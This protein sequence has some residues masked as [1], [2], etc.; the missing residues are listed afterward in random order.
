MWNHSRN[1]RWKRDIHGIMKQVYDVQRDIYGNEDLDFYTA[2]NTAIYERSA[3]ANINNDLLSAWD[4][5]DEL[6]RQEQDR[7]NHGALPRR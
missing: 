1:W 3:E 7:L 5:Y 4:E 2:W 6:C